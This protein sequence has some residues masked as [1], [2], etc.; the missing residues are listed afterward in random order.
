MYDPPTAAFG[1]YVSI[2][3]QWMIKRIAL[4]DLSIN[5]QSPFIQFLA[6]SKCWVRD[7]KTSIFKMKRVFLPPARTHQPLPKD[8]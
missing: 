2:S 3:D 8:C 7:S 6:D 5:V 4:K 1:D